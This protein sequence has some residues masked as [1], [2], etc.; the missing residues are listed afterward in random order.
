MYTITVKNIIDNH[1]ILILYSDW[2]EECIS[3][4]MLCF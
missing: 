1:I 2:R 4:S 3:F